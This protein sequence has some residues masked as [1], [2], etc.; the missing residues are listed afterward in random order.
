MNVCIQIQSRM[1]VGAINI[2]FIILVSD[3]ISFRI[4]WEQCAN[5]LGGSSL[6]I[7]NGTI[8]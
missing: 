5:R 4:F 8:I 3:G 6:D 7:E 1:M 2:N